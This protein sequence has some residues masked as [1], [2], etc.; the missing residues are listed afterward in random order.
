MDTEQQSD[1]RIPR[2][3]KA[4]VPGY[5]AGNPALMRTTTFF[6]AYKDVPLPHQ[7]GYDKFLAEHPELPPPVIKMAD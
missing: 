6:A 3:I 2:A 7:Q 4:A 5:L 1:G